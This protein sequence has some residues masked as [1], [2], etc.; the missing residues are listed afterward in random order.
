MAAHRVMSE[1]TRERAGQLFA[2]L[3]NP[4]RLRVTELLC[5]GER[6]VGSIAEAVGISQSSASQHLA[7][8]ARA[9]VVVCER[10]GTSHYY[11]VR[12]PRIGLILDIIEEFCH[13]HSL[14]GDKDLEVSSDA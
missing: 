8:L 11:G 4:M 3:A 13:V 12:G 6:T 14:F 5:S 10:R 1:P 9:G 2:A 7:I